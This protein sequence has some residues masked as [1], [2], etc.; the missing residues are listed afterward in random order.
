MELINAVQAGNHNQIRELLNQEIDIHFDDDLALFYAVHHNNL[1][2]VRE[3][4]E[5]RI[6]KLR[7]LR[8]F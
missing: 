3:L 6:F 4:L 5:P 8:S 7:R 2:I 1:N